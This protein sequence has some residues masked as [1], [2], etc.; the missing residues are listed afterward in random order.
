MDE[1]LKRFIKRN[2]KKKG[3]NITVATMV[4]FLLSCNGVY[5]END[6]IQIKDIVNNGILNELKLY[7]SNHIANLINLKNNGKIISQEGKAIDIYGKLEGNINALENSGEIQGI[8]VSSDKLIQVKGIYNNGI[9]SGEGIKIDSLNYGVED[10]DNIGVIRGKE[11]AISARENGTLLDGINNF[12]LLIGKAPI[13]NK[14][15]NE[16]NNGL[17]ISLDNSGEVVKIE[18]ENKNGIT[19]VTVDYKGTTYTVIN[20]EISENSTNTIGIRELSEKNSNLILNGVDNT[21]TVDESFTLNDSVINAYKTAIKIEGN[22]MFTGNNIVVNGGGLNGETAVISGDENNNTLNLSGNTVINGNIDL[23]DGEDRLV[24]GTSD[25]T[26]TYSTNNS[27]NINSNISGVENIEVNQNVNISQESKISGVE[28]ITIG[29]SGNLTLGLK[30]NGEKLEH[31]LTESGATIVGTGVEGTGN[32]VFNTENIG[33]EAIIDMTGVK[34]ENVSVKT[35]SDLYGVTNTDGEDFKVT[36]EGSLS[37]VIGNGSQNGDIVLPEGYERLE[38]VF[39]GFT[40]SSDFEEIKGKLTKADKVVAYTKE[41]AFQSPYALS[42]ELSRKSIKGFTNI[43]EDKDL[44]PELGSW[45]VTGGLTHT[46]GGYSSEGLLGSNAKLEKYRADVDS[47]LTGIYTF[48]E[49]GL[50]KD[51]TLGLV[52]GANNLKSELT[53]GS[54]V[55]GTSIYLG[56]F[57]KK[58]LGNLRLLAGAGYQYGDYQGERYSIIGSK[59]EA[60]YSDNAFTIYTDAK[61][62]HMI[63]E[64]LYL[65]PSVGLDYIYISQEG[66][67]ENGKGALHLNSKDLDYTGAKIALDI[68]KDIVTA[69]VKHSLVAGAFYDVILDGEKENSITTKFNGSKEFDT[70]IA[71]QNEH[72]LGLRAKYEVALES[73]VSFDI[74]GNYIFA[75]DSYSGVDK[76]KA[77]SEWS[78]GAGIGYKF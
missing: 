32:L 2:N 56:G 21:L 76:N 18:S 60:S 6:T 42:S 45:A 65:E 4:I 33:K 28:Q 59:N 77:K 1:L 62:S 63:G 55:D 40:S 3:L 14:T 48:G 52:F 58:Y 61:Y 75:R 57:A 69:G 26:T 9:I 20:I 46:D 53:N 19:G 31:A 71:G 23:G 68:R 13:S 25:G 64:N 51:L 8:R 70:V 37:G 43:V 72:N 7:S 78:L 27:V 24:F 54:N 5:A 38:G 12:G 10:I 39:Q 47:K 17:K 36:V 73:G 67:D 16:I 29:S 49:Y 35:D 34:L 66:I 44:K 74:K 50:D 30:D 22:N 11:N 41:I 15:T